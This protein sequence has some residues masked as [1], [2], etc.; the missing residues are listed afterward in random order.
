M[1]L[2]PNGSHERATRGQTS[3]KLSSRHQLPSCTQAS[4]GISQGTAGIPDA[5]VP[6]SA[7]ACSADFSVPGAQAQLPEGAHC[8]ASWKCTQSPCTTILQGAWYWRGQLYL[9]FLLVY[10]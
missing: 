6:C 9:D 10:V 4:S 2:S 8:R 3:P 1:C 5:A 7:C